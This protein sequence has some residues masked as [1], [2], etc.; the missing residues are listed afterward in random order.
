MNYLH[1]FFTE[2]VCLDKSNSYRWI[3]MNFKEYVD[4]GPENSLLNFVSDPE[5]ILIF[6]RIY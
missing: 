3:F 5:Q 4:Y 1:H 2:Y 6:N